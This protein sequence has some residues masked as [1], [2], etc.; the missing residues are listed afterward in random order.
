MIDFFVPGI[1]APGGSKRHV[2]NGR[3]VE[4]CKRTAGWRSVVAGIAMQ[5]YTGKP[6]DGMLVLQIEFSMPRPR[7]HYRKNGNLK[8]TAPSR[9][10]TRPDLTKLV[11]STEDA[12]KGILWHDDSQIVTQC[13]TKLYAER[14]GARVFVSRMAEEVKK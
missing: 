8:E 13:V 2:G 4:A 11:R 3:I 14:P 7:G 5:A 1:P 12:L 10:I 6:L 9:P